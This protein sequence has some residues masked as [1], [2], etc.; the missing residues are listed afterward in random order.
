LKLI[1][2]LVIKEVRGVHNGGFERICM[3]RLQQQLAGVLCERKAGCMPS[4]RQCEY[5][6][7]CAG[8]R[9]GQISQGRWQGQGPEMDTV[10]V[11]EEDNSGQFPG[12]NAI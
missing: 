11:S 2:Y 10:G 6:T 8:Q 12:I 9:V 1:S 3:C 7:G 5:S 4:V